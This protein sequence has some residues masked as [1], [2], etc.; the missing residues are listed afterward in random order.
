MR[1]ITPYQGDIVR[2]PTKSEKTR[3]RV[4]YKQGI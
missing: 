3:F 1:K 2:R 4:E